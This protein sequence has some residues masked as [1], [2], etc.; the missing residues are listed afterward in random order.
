[1]D[2]G[3]RKSGTTREAHDFFRCEDCNAAGQAIA[4]SVSKIRRWSAAVITLSPPPEIGE[5]EDGPAGELEGVGV[6]TL[7]E[8][9]MHAVFFESERL[10]SNLPPRAICS[11]EWDRL[12][13][14][15]DAWGRLCDAQDARSQSRP[16]AVP[17]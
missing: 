14:A 7:T 15:H 17:R 4:E 2:D 12:C 9:L 13:D 16:K 3:K 5:N 10:E 6:A 1:M 11:E 8:G